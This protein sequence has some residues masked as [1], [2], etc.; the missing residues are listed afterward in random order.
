M[1]GQR[2][3]ALPVRTRAAEKAVAH[4]MTMVGRPSDPQYRKTIVRML[5]SGAL[6]HDVVS[7]V[8]LGVEIAVDVLEDEIAKEELNVKRID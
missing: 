6:P 7:A 5:H 3:R 8:R 2:R 1:G 4:L